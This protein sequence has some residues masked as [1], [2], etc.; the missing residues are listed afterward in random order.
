M[1]I[2]NTEMSMCNKHTEVVYVE[3][4]YL[5]IAAQTAEVAQPTLFKRAGQHGQSR[6]Q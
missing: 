6:Q 1:T 4:V 3:A 2:K 5:Y